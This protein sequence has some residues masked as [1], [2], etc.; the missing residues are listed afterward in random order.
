MLG[1]LVKA[2]ECLEPGLLGHSSRNLDD[3]VAKDDL[4]CECLTQK[5]S[6]ENIIMWPRNHSCDIWAKNLTAF[7]IV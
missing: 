3:I 5:V 2:L 1:L 4:K 6:E 7:T